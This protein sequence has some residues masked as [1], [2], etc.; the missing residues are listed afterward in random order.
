MKLMMGDVHPDKK[1]ENGDT[2]LK[3]ELVEE[4][5]PPTTPEEGKLLMKIAR[6]K[7]EEGDTGKME[8]LRDIQSVFDELH[9]EKVLER[10]NVFATPDQDSGPK[11]S[12]KRLNVTALTPLIPMNLDKFKVKN[13]EFSSEQNLL[14]RGQKNRLQTPSLPLIPNQGGRNDSDAYHSGMLVVAEDSDSEVE[15]EAFRRVKGDL[16]MVT[17]VVDQGGDSVDSEAEE[18]EDSQTKATDSEDALW[19]QDL[20]RVAKIRSTSKVCRLLLYLLE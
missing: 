20:A 16:E 9:Q 7:Y 6:K 11:Q 1:Q 13:K 12:R 5:T 8:A 4:D 15:A 18:G 3:K 19:K 17:P 2:P 14:G 10:V